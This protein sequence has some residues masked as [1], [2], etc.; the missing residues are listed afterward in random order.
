MILGIFN[1]AHRNIKFTSENE[2][3]N[4][5]PFLDVLLK[6]REDGTLQRSVYQKPTASG[7]YLHFESA[8][9]IEHKRGLVKT[10]FN[11]A[12]RICTP[13]TLSEIEDRITKDLSKNSYPASFIAYHKRPKANANYDVPR[14]S[15][16]IT[17]PFKGDKVNTIIR[18]RLNA[19]I[20]R[21]YPAAQLRLLNKSPKIGSS[22]TKVKKSFFAESKC[23]YQFECT[24]GSRYI[25]RTERRLDCRAREHI[26]A[27]LVNNGSGT[28]HTAVTKHVMSCDHIDRNNID[29][30]KVFSI[31]NRQHSLT[32]LKLAEACLIRRLQPDLC[33]QKQYVIPLGLPWG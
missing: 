7:Q 26:P 20:Q 2:M 31:V 17:L 14:K 25:G 4:Q 9:P 13:D 16:Y 30:R 18:T 33:V 15:V 27:W 24:C 28:A 29:R 5:I 11:R 8:S 6:R 3:D 32:L 21:T 1:E 22:N 19:M 23:I 10:L 12:R